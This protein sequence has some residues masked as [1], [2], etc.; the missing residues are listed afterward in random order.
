MSKNFI[1]LSIYKKYEDA[2]NALLD[3]GYNENEI[4]SM[5]YNMPFCE[6][7]AN[8]IKEDNA[9]LE[10]LGLTRSMVHAFIIGRYQFYSLTV[11]EVKKEFQKTEELGVNKKEAIEL[12][13]HSGFFKSN[14]NSIKYKNALLDFGIPED[15][16]M[17]MIHTKPYTYLKIGFYL[18][19]IS[20]LC[21]NYKKYDYSKLDFIDMIMN[22]TIMLVDINTLYSI[23]NDEEACKYIA[24][25]IASGLDKEDAVKETIRRY[26]ELEHKRDEEFYARRN[27]PNRVLKKF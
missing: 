8:N 11:E 18:D 5:L 7:L 17:L 6:N 2:I 4:A 15:K 25:A 1:I 21:R 12:N 10:S 20:S 19:K 16:I 27:A 23:L 14:G 3:Y 13:V 9:Y 24:E 26:R 22:N